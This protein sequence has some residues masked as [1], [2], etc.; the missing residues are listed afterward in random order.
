GNDR[1]G[2]RD[3]YAPAGGRGWRA[4]PGAAGV[5][6]R[7]PHTPYGDLGAGAPLDQGQP[8][9]NGACQWFTGD[10]VFALLPMPDTADGPQASLVWSMPEGRAREWLALDADAQQAF[11]AGHAQAIT[12]GRLG[13]LRLRTRPQGFSL[14]LE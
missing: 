6:H 8:P 3:G 10:S 5:R 14:T 1:T 2:P 13:A 12:G 7:T 11:F 9:Q 4:F